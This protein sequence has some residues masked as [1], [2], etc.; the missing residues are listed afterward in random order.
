MPEYAD[1]HLHS[2]YSE[3]SLSCSE[4]IQQA[5]RRKIKVLSLTDHNGIEGVSEITEWGKKAKIKVIPGVEI[6]TTYQRRKLHLLGYGFRPDDQNLNKTLK[7]L[8]TIHREDIQSSFSKLISRGFSINLADFKKLKSKYVGQAQI[9][10][11]LNKSPKNRKIIKRDLKTS[12]PD[13]F[14]IINYYFSKKGKAP[15]PE[16]SIPIHKAIKLIKGAGGMAVLAH[17]GQKLMWEDDY[18]ILELKKFGLDGIEVLS[19]YHHWHQIEHY[20]HFVKKN[21]LIMTG[22]SDFHSELPD[23]SSIVKSQWDYFQIPKKLVNNFIN[24]LSKK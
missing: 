24:T 9:V 3:G 8:Q 6:Y 16:S 21:K 14:R 19:P 12:Q 10:F 18:V 2:H 1:L 13:L 15:L 17:P 5:K 11:L 4:I 20:Q 22:G 23:K 7:K